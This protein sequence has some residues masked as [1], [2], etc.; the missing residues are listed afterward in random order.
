LYSL[1]IINQVANPVRVGIFTFQ[2]EARFDVE[3]GA[4][5]MPDVVFE[6]G[7]HMVVVWDALGGA[8]HPLVASAAI[9]M[10]GD[11]GL[12][13]KPNKIEAFTPVAD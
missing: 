11:T 3:A 5:V 9:T 4:T 1:K 13:I 10:Q 2:S 7:H 12:N 6:G 8:P